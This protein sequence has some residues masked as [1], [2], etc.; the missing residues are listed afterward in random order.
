MNIQKNF[1]VKT[2]LKVTSNVARTDTDI[3]QHWAPGITGIR[4]LR[5]AIY[6]T[7]APQ[8]RPKNDCPA[9][10]VGPTRVLTEF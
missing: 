4:F 5:W 7:M 10:I 3:R 2:F 6:V 8:C 9:C 1:E